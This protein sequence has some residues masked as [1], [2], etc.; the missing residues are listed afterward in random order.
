MEVQKNGEYDDRIYYYNVN[1]LRAIVAGE[2]ENYDRITNRL[3]NDSD[4]SL[5]QKDTIAKGIKN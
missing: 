3:N 4:I 2:Y 5:R 1:D